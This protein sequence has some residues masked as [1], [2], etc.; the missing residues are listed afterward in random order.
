VGLVLAF[1]TSS[2]TEGDSIKER[3][4]ENKDSKYNF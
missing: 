3:Y 2:V 1:S 4:N